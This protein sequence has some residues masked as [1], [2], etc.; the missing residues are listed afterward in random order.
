[1]KKST[2]VFIFSVLVSCFVHARDMQA[3]MDAWWNARYQ[4]STPPQIIG[5]IG[6]NLLKVTKM[7]FDA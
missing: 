4:N 1:M 6:H 7:L 5:A 2:I 3:E